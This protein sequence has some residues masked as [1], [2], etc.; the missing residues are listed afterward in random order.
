[1]HL[2]NT[3]CAR[4]LS[5]WKFHVKPAFSF[6]IFRGEQYF[7]ALII[8]LFQICLV[9]SQ[10]LGKSKLLKA[11][12]NMLRERWG[13]ILAWKGNEYPGKEVCLVGLG[14]GWNYLRYNANSCHIYGTWRSTEVGGRLLSHYLGVEIH[15]GGNSFY[16]GVELSRHHKRGSP[17]VI[18]LTWNFSC[19][20]Y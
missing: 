10:A 15:K 14:F 9:I 18:L 11:L 6:N 19:K 7:D 13:V 12:V 17:Y 3:L 5:G 2:K 8:K 20:S 1:M 16:G 4:C